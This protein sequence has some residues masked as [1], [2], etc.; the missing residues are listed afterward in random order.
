MYRFLM[1]FPTAG[2]VKGYTEREK[3]GGEFLG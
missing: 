2:N 3:V 1:D